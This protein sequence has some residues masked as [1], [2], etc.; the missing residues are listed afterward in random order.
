MFCK[1]SS[2]RHDCDLRKICTEDLR[3]STK[4]ALDRELA[5]H[6]CVTTN[7]I[8]KKL[9]N[10]YGAWVPLPEQK[11]GYIN[12]SKVTLTEDQKEILNLGVNFQFAPR[13]SQQQ[14][15]AELEML[16]Q[17]A[18][19]LRAQ[20][21]IDIDPN[22]QDDLIGES[23]KNRSR[24]NKSLP[25]RMRKAARELRENDSIVIRK[26]DKS[27]VY[28]IMDKEDYNQKV[29]SILDDRTKFLP[30]S[31]NPVEQL[32]SKANDLIGS[33]NA[34]ITNGEKISKITGEYAPGYFYGNPKTHKDN[35]PLRPII[36]QIPLPTYQLAKHL[37]KVLSAYVPGTYSLRSSDEFI[38]LL[39][40]K[41]KRGLLASLDV[42]SL[43]TN[44]PV[45]RTIDILMEYAFRNSELAPPEIP[46]HT[47]R[48]MLRLCTTKAPFRSP[49]GNLFYQTDGIAMGS[50]LGVLFAQAFM[51]HVEQVV[52]DSGN[53]EKPA[54]YCRY[55]DDVLVDVNSLSHL[56]QLKTQ[57][58]QASGLKF[59]TEL[60]V[61][62]R[63]NFLDV[64]LDGSC[65]TFKTSV[66][67]KPTDMGRCLNGDSSC[68]DRYKESVISAYVTRAIKHCSSWTLLHV[69]LR[70]VKQMLVN[71]RYPI[72]MID[73]YINKAL[74]KLLNNQTS[75]HETHSEKQLCQHS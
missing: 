7:K 70:R 73:N 2:K 10:I 25:P 60:S 12:L 4:V 53:V 52:L 59:T 5:Q 67:R 8:Q 22:F 68:P 39:R 14:K 72:T 56:S 65:G 40:E 18:L 41:E 16:Y 50:P 17:D 42:C 49:D 30:I 37:N 9:S 13:F 69:E 75:S 63:I 66:F 45:E 15:R 33:A 26:A 61:G 32:K 23:T 44:V 58:E 11:D 48:A 1:Q 51:A 47:M 29:S 36:S 20:G 24:V 74:Q 3:N 35:Y 57:L 64:S 62:D 43:F 38:D 54:L 31:R 34:H 71:N 55:V 28:V 46:E 6:R 21:K 19:K 27:A